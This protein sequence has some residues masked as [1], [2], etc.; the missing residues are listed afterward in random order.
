[1]FFPVNGD[2]D[3]PNIALHLPMTGP[4]NS[5]SFIDVSPIPKTITR[6]GGAIISSAQSKWGQGSGY[7]DG[8]G[9][10]I[11]STDTGI[12]LD[13][14]DFTIEMYAF[15]IN[16]GK[17]SQYYTRLFESANWVSGGVSGSITLA[18]IP[19]QNP[20]TLF[21]ELEYAGGMNPSQTLAN[22]T[23]HHIAVTRQNN[24]FRL[25]YNGIL[26]GSLSK[27]VNLSKQAWSFGGAGGARLNQE[28]FYGYLQDL[29]IIK[30]IARYTSDFAPP[31]GP[32]PIRLPESS[33]CTTIQPSFQQIRQLGL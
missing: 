26:V 22:N 1:M 28:N 23:W 25:F 13:L 9:D 24:L 18:T 21:C 19:N 12:I 32:L 17:A 7:F 16:G 5:T 33:V 15:F 3:Y 8:V 27:V 29:R 4:N 11:H 10:S 31:S 20:T 2:V 6:N 30:G 14:S